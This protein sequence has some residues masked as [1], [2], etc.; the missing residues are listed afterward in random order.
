MA[1]TVAEVESEIRGLSRPEQEHLLGVILEELDD[2]ADPTAERAWLEELQ[3][4]TA[5]FDAGLV[6]AAPMEEVLGRVRPRL[7]R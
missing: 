4:R 1:R 6:A 5:E 7:E 2:L 3:R